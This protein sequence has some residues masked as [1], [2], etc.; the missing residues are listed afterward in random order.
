MKRRLIIGIVSC[1]LVIIFASCNTK[2]NVDSAQAKSPSMSAGDVQN[3]VVAL[4][5]GELIQPLSE[6]N[7][8]QATFGFGGNKPYEKPT[9]NT[10]WVTIQAD[11]CMINGSADIWS[12]T[13]DDFYENDVFTMD[14]EESH[15]FAIPYTSLVYTPKYYEDFWIEFPDAD[16]TGEIKIMGYYLNR[17]SGQYGNLENTSV[18]AIVYYAKQGETIAFS[19]QSVAKAIENLQS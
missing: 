10:A 14:E 11:G 2:D 3:V 7:Q 6:D 18:R 19:N 4:D 8:I 5:M 13:F 17:N 9:G 12:K 15:M 1:I 16:C